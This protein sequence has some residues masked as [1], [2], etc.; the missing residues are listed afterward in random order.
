MPLPARG[1]VR[2]GL[3]TFIRLLAVALVAWQFSGMAARATDEIQVYNADITPRGTFSLEQH[4]N[5]IWNGSQVPPFPGGIAPYHTLNGTPELAYGVRDWWE[6]G[7]YMPFS[8]DSNGTYLPGG[9]KVRTLFVSPHAEERKLFYGLNTEI[10]YQT[11][12]FSQSAVGVEFRP[13][14]GVRDIGWELIVNP[15]V[16]V[17]FGPYGEVDFVPA[18]R[19]ARTIAEETMIGV[20]Y[21]ADFGPLGNFSPADQ[22]QHTIFGVIDF[23]MFTLDVEFGMGVGLTGGSDALVSKMIVGRTF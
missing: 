9:F 5:Y 18:V 13:I 10:S 12:R 20:E 6:L 16:D 4:L 19:L 15:I 21:Y 1:G 14:L 11:P 23:K 8:F 2:S 17:S 3:R 7:L 22:Q